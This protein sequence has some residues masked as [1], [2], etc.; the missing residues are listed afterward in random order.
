M[1]WEGFTAARLYVARPVEVGLKRYGRLDHRSLCD[2][3][4]QD[5]IKEIALMR[6]LSTRDSHVVPFYGV[7]SHGLCGLVMCV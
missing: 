6:I 5:F 4:E 3:L 1:M 2:R 7:R